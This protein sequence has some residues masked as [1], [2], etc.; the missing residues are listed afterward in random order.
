[1]QTAVPREQAY[2]AGIRF[3]PDR[4]LG[5]GLHPPE[6][7]HKNAA[8]A[9]SLRHANPEVARKFPNISRNLEILSEPRRYVV[10]VCSTTLCSSPLWMPL[11]TEVAAGHLDGRGHLGPQRH[12][13]MAQPV[14]GKS[15][16]AR[17]VSE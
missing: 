16:S 5:R 13:M 9:S 3:W 14:P 1:M 2:L 11:L 6:F 12:S 10:V 17:A 4:F 7:E 15:A 8:D